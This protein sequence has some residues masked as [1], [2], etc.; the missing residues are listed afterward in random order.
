MQGCGSWGSV[1]GIATLLRFGVRIPIGA[2]VFFLLACS[3]LK[4]KKYYH[5]LPVR[6]EQGVKRP[7]R[8]VD[9]SSLS[10]SNVTNV[11]SCTPMACS[12]IQEREGSFLFSNVPSALLPPEP[13]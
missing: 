9:R 12:G 3:G 7:G 11:C 1:I 13:D 5:E 4:M 8:V 10:S 2:R 6:T